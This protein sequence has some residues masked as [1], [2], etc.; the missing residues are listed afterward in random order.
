MIH[1]F[2]MARWILGEE[3]VTIHSHGS[4]LVDPQIGQLGDIDTAC[5]TMVTLSGK[6]AVILNSRRAVYGYDQRVEAFGSTGMVI[7][8]N[9]RATAVQRFSSSSFGAP[10]RVF[11]FFMDRYGYSYR[12]EIE[13]FLG[14]VA[15]GTPAPV[16]AIDG[17]RAVYLAEAAGASLRSGKNIELNSNCEVTWHD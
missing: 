11:T 17:L 14:G 9:P 12:K 7:S 5:V 3:P 2:D 6:Q 1:D 15:A 4:C 10:D 8:D 13:T 16:N